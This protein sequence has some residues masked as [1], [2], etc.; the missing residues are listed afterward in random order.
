MILFQVTLTQ[1]VK[2]TLFLKKIDLES[3]CL[4]KN[5]KKNDEI[6]FFHVTLKIMIDEV[7]EMFF[8][9]S[10][11]KTVNLKIKQFS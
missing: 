4:M 10:Y 11:Q 7:D 8:F 1:N 5:E 9:M 2:M 6:E 3:I